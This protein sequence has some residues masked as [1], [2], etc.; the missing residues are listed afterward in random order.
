MRLKRVSQKVLKRVLKHKHKWDVEP[1]FELIIAE[2][3]EIKST[4]VQE[5]VQDIKKQIMHL[6]EHGQ[7][8]PAA[9]MHQ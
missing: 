4:E 2:L 5:E 3:D 6:K 8:M 1:N 9:K 7:V